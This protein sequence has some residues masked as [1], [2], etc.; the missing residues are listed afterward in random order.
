MPMSG[1]SG[2]AAFG[3]GEARTTSGERPGAK[4]VAE[5]MQGAKTSAAVG[6]QQK[7]RDDDGTG[8]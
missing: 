8:A 3:L 2:D 7:E 4:L 6:Q 1:G 5:T